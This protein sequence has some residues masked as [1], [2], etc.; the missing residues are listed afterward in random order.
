MLIGAG[1]KPALSQ[2]L[3]AAPVIARIS[4][5]PRLREEGGFK[6]RPY[7]RHDIRAPQ[8]LSPSGLSFAGCL[9][10]MQ[11]Q[12][13]S[14]SLSHRE[15]VRVRG[16]VLKRFRDPLTPALSPTGE[17]ERTAIAALSAFVLV[18]LC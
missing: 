1:F 18:T 13:Q 6:T 5:E 14:H 16:H 4:G 3:R 7:K 2:M 8:R 10:H 12:A 17:R 15:R 11:R 9:R